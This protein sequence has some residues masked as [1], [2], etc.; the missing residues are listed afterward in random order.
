MK[1]LYDALVRR[2]LGYLNP[3]PFAIQAGV[4]FGWVV[5]GYCVRDPFIIASNVPGLM[6]ALWLNFG[7]TKLQYMNVIFALTAPPPTGDEERAEKE[8]RRIQEEM[9]MVPQERILFGLLIAWTCVLVVAGFLQPIG[10]PATVVGIAVN[11][12]FVLYYGAPLEKMK[13]VIQTGDA[14]PIHIPTM[15]LSLANAAFWMLYGGLHDDLAM[16]LPSAIGAILALMQGA[17]LLKYRPYRAKDEELQ[18]LKGGS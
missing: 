16:I 15:I 3:F 9:I 1:S 5:Y 13:Q 4:N 12:N 14:S 2:N 17:L 8:K 18:P 10:N 7:A 6:C 11:L